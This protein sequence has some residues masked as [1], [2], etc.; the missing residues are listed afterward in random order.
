MFGEDKMQIQLCPYCTF[1]NSISSTT[2]KNCGAILAASPLEELPQ[3]TMLLGGRF[4]T[5]RMLGRGGFGIT[6]LARETKNGHKVA[7]KELFPSNL[8]T[9]RTD[10]EI[11][12]NVGAEP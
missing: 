9:R 4:E 12:P 7:I 1:K 10:N 6:Y 11:K 5:I 3:K 8:V 2:C